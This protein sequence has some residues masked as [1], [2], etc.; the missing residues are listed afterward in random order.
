MSFIPHQIN[1]C[2]ICFIFCCTISIVQRNRTK[3]KIKIQWKLEKI[4]VCSQIWRY[5]I[6]YMVLIQKEIFGHTMTCQSS[7][8]ANFNSTV[9]QEKM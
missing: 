5:R 6:R 9:V 1:V 8:T 7:K 2:E 4:Q 3:L